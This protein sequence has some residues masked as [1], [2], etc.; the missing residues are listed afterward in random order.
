[1]GKATF[2]SVDM[3]IQQ[4]IADLDITPH[5][6]LQLIE[7]YA[8]KVAAEESKS[9]KMWAKGKQDVEGMVDRCAAKFVSQEDRTYTVV[10]KKHERTPKSRKRVVNKMTPHIYSRVE[11]QVHQQAS[12]PHMYSGV[13]NHVHQQAPYLVDISVPPPFFQGA[14]RTRSLNY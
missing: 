1:M 9:Q 7:E 11:T 3:D 12:Y 4:I 10:P 14:Y 8:S 5:Q 6:R 13:G 2:D